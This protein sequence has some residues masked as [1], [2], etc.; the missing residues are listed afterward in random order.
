MGKVVSIFRG[1][2][3]RYYSPGSKFR[4]ILDEVFFVLG[5]LGTMVAPQ[6]VYC[7]LGGPV[8]PSVFVICA[9]AGVIVGLVKYIRPA[10]IPSIV[11]AQTAPISRDENTKRRKLS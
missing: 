10:T 3:L 4:T 1:R 2:F 5:V 8:S 11:E 7:A 6:V 9:Q